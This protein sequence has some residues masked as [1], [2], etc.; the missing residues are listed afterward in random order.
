MSIRDYIEA[1][2]REK[3]E[4][5]SVGIGGFTMLVR[6]S[7]TYSRSVTIPTVYLENGK[8]VN[9]HIIIEPLILTISGDV[10]DVHLAPSTTATL[11]DDIQSDIGSVDAYTPPKTQ[12]QLSVISGIANDINDAITAIDI[13]VSKSQALLGNFGSKSEAETNTQSFL[14]HMDAMVTGNQLSSIEM[15]S[16]T[17]ENMYITSFDASYDNVLGSTGFTIVAAQFR[18]SDT[19][20]TELI[21]KDPASGTNGSLEKESD[22]ST[23]EPPM[24]EK[25]TDS[26]LGYIVRKFN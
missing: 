8:H 25:G 7:E 4:T 1:P 26:F 23:Q 6:T 12:Q 22:K 11:I 2:F 15:N 24:T 14:N 10:S 5:S 21:V 3:V 13:A 19:L 9:D 16:R 18:F 20:T 17:Y